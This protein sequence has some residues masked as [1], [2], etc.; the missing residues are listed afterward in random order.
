MFYRIENK[1]R[2]GHY[3]SS[4]FGK[5]CSEFGDDYRLYRT[6][7]AAMRVARKLSKTYSV[8]VLEHSPAWPHMEE[9]GQRA[10]EVANGM[11]GYA[12]SAAEKED[13]HGR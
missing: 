8:A 4:H 1:A 13:R 5:F 2:P 7:G 12:G 10:F 6:K 3:W 9:P 11:R